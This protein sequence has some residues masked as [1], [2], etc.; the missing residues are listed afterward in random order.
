MPSWV[1]LNPADSTAGEQATTLTRVWVERVVIGLNLCPF[2]KPVHVRKQIQYTVSQASDED[3]LARDLLRTMR[4]L[5]DTPAA[6]ADTCLLIHPW[7][8]QDFIDYN[9][10]LDMADTLL[11]ET[12]LTGVLQ[13]ASFHP[14][15]RFAGTAMN[16]ITNYT[17]RSPFPTLHL[18]REDSLDKAIAA[19]PDASAIVDRNLATLN[20]LGHAGWAQLQHHILTTAQGWQN[21]D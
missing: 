21:A 17:N 5:M 1:S 16:E 10:F 11:E 3:T 13:I 6:I 14:D 12:G 8:L 19:L 4:S 7:V 20:S 15:Y 9:D 18:L 2:A